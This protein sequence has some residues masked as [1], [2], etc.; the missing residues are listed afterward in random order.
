VAA[1]PF[2]RDRALCLAGCTHCHQNLN[3]SSVCKN[4]RAGSQT[5]QASR[6]PGAARQPELK[7]QARR[8]EAVRSLAASAVAVELL[9]LQQQV[10]SLAAAVAAEAAEQCFLLARDRQSCHARRTRCRR[11]QAQ[12]WE[13]ER[14]REV[15]PPP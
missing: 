14:H 4:G 5:D 3:R 12:C 1:Q 13:A 11:R 9:A 10:Q 7:L 15:Q 8:Q 6:L 2:A